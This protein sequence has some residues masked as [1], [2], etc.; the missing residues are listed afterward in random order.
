VPGDNFIENFKL[1]RVLFNAKSK[2]NTRS[3]ALRKVLRRV[4][5]VEIVTGMEKAQWTLFQA[6]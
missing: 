4:G 5:K 1:L 3:T 6:M 2:T